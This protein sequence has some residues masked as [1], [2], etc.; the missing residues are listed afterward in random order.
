M[1]PYETSKF[2]GRVHSL[3]ASGPMQAEKIRRLE[4]AMGKVLLVYPD[5][6]S[7]GS[8]KNQFAYYV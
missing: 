6:K 2:L 1:K 8:I 4:K 5:W 3:R 7:L